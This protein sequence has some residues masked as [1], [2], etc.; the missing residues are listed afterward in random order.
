MEEI[1]IDYDITATDVYFMITL[2]LD[3]LGIKYEESGEGTTVTIKYWV[4]P[5]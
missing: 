2:L 5:K 4:E 3:K 1:K